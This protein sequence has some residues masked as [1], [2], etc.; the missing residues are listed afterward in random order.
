MLASND[1]VSLTEHHS[2]NEV[3]SF[4]RDQGL[5]GRILNQTVIVE[6]S[7]NIRNDHEVSGFCFTPQDGNSILSSIAATVRFLN[8]HSY[9]D[10]INSLGGFFF[11]R[12]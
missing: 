2:T 9:Q 10:K 8:P 4:G 3:F 12:V 11:D 5:Y 7:I 6:D 1:R